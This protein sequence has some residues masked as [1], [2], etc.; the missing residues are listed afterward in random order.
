MKNWGG[1]N[2]VWATAFFLGA[3]TVP[4]E[5]NI[6]DTAAHRT[7]LGVEQDDPWCSY[8]AGLRSHL[9][10]KAARPSD[11][12]R[13]TALA[14]VRA[15]AAAQHDGDP[16]YAARK[17]LACEF[18][19]SAE[20][21]IAEFDWPAGVAFMELARAAM[22][23]PRPENGIGPIVPVVDHLNGAEPESLEPIDF[24][25]NAYCDELGT[26]ELALAQQRGPTVESV[27][28]P[29]SLQRAPDWFAHVQASYHRW[30]Q[31]HVEGHQLE[32]GDVDFGGIPFHCKRFAAA[33]IGAQE[34]ALKDNLIFLL[35]ERDNPFDAGR[36]EISD[37]EGNVVILDEVLEAAQLGK[38]GVGAQNVE[39]YPED[40]AASAT[41]KAAVDRANNLP[42]PEVFVVYFDYNERS[43]VEGADTGTQALRS[44]LEGLDPAESIRIAISGHADCVGP[45]WYN[46]MIAA[47]RITATADEVIKPALRVAGFTEDLLN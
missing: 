13:A 34:F 1:L 18:L 15:E 45:R 38:G 22:E 32:Q 28:F 39:F 37:A 6:F 33:S 29:G 20:E 26:S 10:G 31:E 8:M 46:K 11:G 7:L 19:Q 30:A 47:D 43:P 3:C 36:L 4:G 27:G 16:Y 35:A 42:A 17:G 5:P 24:S 44:Y 25:N 21:E 12:A 41:L 14:E 9:D 2:A 40:L 23:T